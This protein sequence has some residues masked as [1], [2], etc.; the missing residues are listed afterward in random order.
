MTSKQYVEEYDGR[1][2]VTADAFLQAQVEFE[3]ELV[4]AGVEIG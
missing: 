2:S 4:N 1:P 3:D